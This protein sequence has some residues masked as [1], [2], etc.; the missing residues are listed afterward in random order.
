MVDKGLFAATDRYVLDLGVI[1]LNQQG[2]ST[3]RLE[4]LPAVS[5]VVGLEIQIVPEDRAKIENRSIKPTILVELLGPQ[6]EP[7][8]RN[9]SSLDT[10]TWSVRAGDGNAFVYRREQPST[11]FTPVANGRY[12]LKVGVVQPDSSDSKYTARVFAKSGGWK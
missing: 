1:A 10:W 5:F 11:F 7:V 8:I 4:N 2:T 9:Q 12:E 3:Y 6:G